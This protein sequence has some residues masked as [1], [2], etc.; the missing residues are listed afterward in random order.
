[1]T[2]QE[3]II[4]DEIDLLPYIKH[5]VTNWRVLVLALISGAFLGLIF[6]FVLP[7]K[8]TA[9]TTFIIPK[10]TSG[11]SGRSGILASLGYSAISGGG[12][13]GL[14]STYLMPIFKSNRMKEHVAQTFF[15]H[16]LFANDKVFLNGSY[17]F[18][19]NYII[20]R[21]N[22]AKAVELN[23]RDGV[24]SISYKTK[25]R[26]LILPVLDTYLASLIELNE[27]LNI[28]SDVLQII[29]LDKAI[30]PQTY[31]FPNLKKMIGLFAGIAF[32]GV[33]LVLI[34]QKIIEI[35][36]ASKPMVFR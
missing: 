34:I 12:T 27:A 5:V 7:K 3:T 17:R 32:A 11:L 20:S 6:S 1:M 33:L 36:K 9:T 2:N 28:D 35:N 29:P 26:D 10:A 31:F 19:T 24:H 22:L 25:N 16:P 14:Y 23:Q 15:D 8:Y 4:D 21:L 18:K 30:T 13:S